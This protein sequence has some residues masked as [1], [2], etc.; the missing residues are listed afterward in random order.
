MQSPGHQALTCM[1]AFLQSDVTHPNNEGKSLSIPHALPK[2]LLPRA[3]SWAPSSHNPI[4]GTLF[5][6]GQV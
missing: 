3:E 2:S 6:V 5:K 4:H 1:P